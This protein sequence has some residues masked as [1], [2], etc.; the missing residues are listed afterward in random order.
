MAFNQNTSDELVLKVEKA[1]DTLKQSGYI[2]Q[3]RNR[4]MD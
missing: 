3:L 4:Y 2:D 1:F